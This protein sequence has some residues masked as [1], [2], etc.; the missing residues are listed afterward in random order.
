MSANPRIWVDFMKTDAQR[1]LI[2][3]T[4][5]TIED[6]KKQGIDLH[7]GLRLEVYSD[8]ADDRGNR[9]DL[10]AEGIVYRDKEQDR[11]V[12]EIDWN[13]IRHASDR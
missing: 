4:L 7:E 6:L 12:L 8:D 11:W 2:L 3:T 9:D 5:G 1:R 10:L 13:A